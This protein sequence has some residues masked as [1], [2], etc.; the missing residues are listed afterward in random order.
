VSVDVEAAVVRIRRGDS[1]VGAGFLAGPGR[2][3]TCAHVVAEALGLAGTP[4][5]PPQEE[6]ELDFPLRAAGT[7]L[8]A[9]VS[10]DCWVPID[11]RTGRGD[12][13]GLDLLAEPPAGARALR[14]VPA[15]D[16]FRHEFTTFGFPAPPPGFEGDPLS[17]A[18]V[19]AHG[20]ILG[21]QAVGHVQLEG[22]SDVGFRIEPGFSGSPIWDLEL[23]GGVGMTVTSDDL[24]ERRTAY[25]IAASDLLAA[26]AAL[27]ASMPP[28]A[29]GSALVTF[30][31]VDGPWAAWAA[32]WV[33]RHGVPAV[34]HAVDAE[35]GDGRL[36]ELGGE[37]RLA[38]A[39]V[40][41][42]CDASG[43]ATAVA[44]SERV[45][46]VRVREGGP[47]PV[48]D[49]ATSVDLVG[50]DRAGAEAALGEALAAA[51]LAPDEAAAATAPPVYP[52]D[53]AD[54][55]VDAGAAEHRQRL[56]QQSEHRR[57][58]RAR[59]VAGRP[60]LDIRSY[61]KDRERERERIRE[62]LAD[63]ATRLVVVVGR[64]G[65][66]KTAV[67][68]QVLGELEE[69]AA[70]SGW[71]GDT[72]SAL[73]YL[74]TRTGEVSLERIFRE[75]GS[76]VDAEARLRLERVW[77]NQNLELGGKVDRLLEELGESLVVVLLDNLEDL[78]GPDGRI[79]DPGI[80]TFVEQTLAGA[81]H[82]TRLLVTTREPIALSGPLLRHDR[83]VPLES[84]LPIADGVALLRELDPDGTFG[85][86]DAPGEKLEQAV[87][88]L[89]GVPRA[90]E[91]LASVAATDF[92][93]LDRLLEDFYDEE[94]VVAD[95]V[96]TSYRR[97]DGDSRLVL[98][99]LAVFTRPVP[100]AAVA[101]LVTPLL[102][103]LDVQRVVRRLARIYLVRV[104]R[105]TETLSLHPVDRDYALS[106]LP[107]DGR[108]AL[109]LAAAGY[110]ARVRIP[111]ESWATIADVE[112]QL[113]EIEHRFAAG[114]LA[115]AAETLSL[116]DGHPL[117]FTWDARRLLALRERLAGALDDPRLRMLHSY[118]L[119]QIYSVLGPVERQRECVED[120][121][122]LARELGDPRWERDSLAWLGDTYRRMGDQD[123]AYAAS[124]QAAALYRKAGDR[125]GESHALSQMSLAE[126]YRRRSESAYE[127]ARRALEVGGADAR[128]AGLAHDALTLAC[129]LLGRLD[130]ALEHA[131]RALALYDEA[132]ASATSPYVINEQG[133]VY[134]RQGRIV[135]AIEALERGRT[136]STEVG[137]PRLAGLT[138]FN[139]AH[140]YL[141]HGDAETALA[142]AETA[143]E[144]LAGAGEPG[145]AEGA[146]ALA[147]A[148]R[149]RLG[150]DS[151]GE[152]EAVA[153][154][155]R[156]VGWNPDLYAA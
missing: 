25:C 121:L 101:A 33:E 80:A 46:A 44:D 7:V 132:H 113:L 30:A 98:S 104:D 34:L 3:L 68:C 92:A 108:R 88:R 67:A 111:P 36:R 94:R 75:C 134:L 76:L 133:M 14:L 55:R 49:A 10:A 126:A 107:D 146:R 142:R 141:A 71:D 127:L 148:A 59:R 147:A 154:S 143:A 24:P 4:P 40:S 102:P 99:A 131:E 28:T 31:S 52:P 115:G 29:A 150:G 77:V 136:L 151:A 20:R 21:R 50:R 72:V 51:G 60:P 129:Y 145:G 93:S 73:V 54:R 48:G 37:A 2:V 45:V 47:W 53:L 57:T 84:G 82:G 79:E 128:S 74:S 112:P 66:G 85:L 123:G 15:D 153:R 103:G 12:V 116:V 56:I 106:L 135:E 8:R 81:D 11:P 105:E 42:V 5:E 83:R 35:A 32:W 70:A 69:N 22:T 19:W 124:E 17:E 100:V 41:P 78:L 86:R 90:L 63:P 114:D 23:R 13:A 89:H 152:A 139:L 137:S 156:A 64:G 65:M 117:A 87:E 26:W 43:A 91:V 27:D 144:A 9:R 149:A 1:A 58:E 97:L 122:S 16:L 119:G 18:G 125:V 95:L 109:E 140:A 62:L 138:L 38:V 96:E 6:L 130:E 110:W 118:G 120:A 61:F 155:A 39:L